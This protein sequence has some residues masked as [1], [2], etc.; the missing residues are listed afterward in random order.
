MSR[1][2]GYFKSQFFCSQSI[3]VCCSE[4]DMARRWNSRKRHFGWVE[5]VTTDVHLVN[6]NIHLT[7]DYVIGHL[8]V[9]RQT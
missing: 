6:S 9:M 8:V 3:I 5:E 4:Y 1:Q 7:T 2:S